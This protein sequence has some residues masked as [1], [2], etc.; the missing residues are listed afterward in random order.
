MIVITSMLIEM[1]HARGLPSYNIVIGFLGV[2][3]KS[4]LVPKRGILLTIG[5]FC[6][7]AVVSIVIDIIYCA[8]WGR[9]ILQGLYNATKFSFFLLILN[10]ILKLF[11]FFYAVAIQ[12]SL[13]ANL[14]IDLSSKL[15][16]IRN[17]IDSDLSIGDDIDDSSIFT[18]PNI[19]HQTADLNENTMR[20]PSAVVS[21]TITPI[22]REDSS[23]TGMLQTSFQEIDIETNDIPFSPGV[24]GLLSPVHPRRLSHGWTPPNANKSH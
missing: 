18:A 15:E 4:K 10:T 7:L 8:L 19:G 20:T 13:S 1:S 2:S 22:Q 6:T 16:T 3:F 11:A 24:P 9:E 17:N 14:D 5:C 21:D 12:I 23:N